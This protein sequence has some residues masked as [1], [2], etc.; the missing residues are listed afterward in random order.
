VHHLRS[1]NHVSEIYITVYTDYRDPFCVQALECLGMIVNV[2]QADVRS[3]ISTF[4]C[5]HTILP[6]A[7][8]VFAKTIK[9]LQKIVNLSDLLGEYRR[10]LTP[11]VIKI[12]DS[13][14]VSVDVRR[15]A[16]CTVM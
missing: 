1:S 11:F 3:V 9:I 5:K 6:L 12:L 14:E 16:L 15:D 2:S 13:A 7:I 10:E 8:S 4:A